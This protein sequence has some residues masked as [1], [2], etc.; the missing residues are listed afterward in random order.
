MSPLIR[1]LKYLNSL[2]IHLTVKNYYTFD[3]ITT[4][5][6]N[7]ELNSQESWDLLRE[8]HPHFSISENRNEW[9]RAAEIQIT[10]DGQDH[11][12][13]QRAQDIA[14]LIER[15]GI[16]SLFSVGV[17]GAGLEYQIKKIKPELALTCS[18]Y[19]APAVAI[20]K[21]V[22]LECN[23]IILF[24]I[25]RSD[26]SAT[27]AAD[28]LKKQLYLMYRIDASF[29]DKEWVKIFDTMAQAGI[30][31]I[32][33]IPTSCLTILGLRNRLYRR[34]FWKLRSIPHAFCGYNRTKTVFKSF[35]QKHY[36]D[37]EVVCGGLHGFLLTR[38][39]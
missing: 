14:R 27:R 9:L 5:L 23:S 24:D 29:L 19:S 32:L 26:W 38:P 25:T 35:W 12:L 7:G 4:R 39:K 18:E 8:S 17:G 37:T 13:L 31:N 20:L 28:D 36:V 33:Y 6:K 34:L 15:L 22:F 21:K 16:T 30:E 3:A 10:K 2:P 11:G 1:F